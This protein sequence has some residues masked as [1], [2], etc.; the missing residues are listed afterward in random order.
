MSCPHP[1]KIDHKKDACK[2]NCMIF[3][4]SYPSCLVAESTI[5]YALPQNSS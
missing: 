2:R 5:E 4:I 3:Y 1:S